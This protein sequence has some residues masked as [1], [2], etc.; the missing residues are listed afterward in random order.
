MNRFDSRTIVLVAILM[1]LLAV[2]TTL[3]R[4]ENETRWIPRGPVFTPC[5]MLNHTPTRTRTWRAMRECVRCDFG[6]PLY[7]QE[8]WVRLTSWCGRLKQEN[9]EL[10]R[11]LQ[12]R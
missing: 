2:G 9:V 10:R 12:R 7:C 4:G 8:C 3:A 11:K 6:L 5:K 1:I